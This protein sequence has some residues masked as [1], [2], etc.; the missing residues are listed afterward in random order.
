[1]RH[2]ER[3]LQSQFT[4]AHHQNFNE[5]NNAAGDGSCARSTR[6]VEKEARREPASMSFSQGAV[7]AMRNIQSSTPDRRQRNRSTTGIS[8]SASRSQLARDGRAI[9]RD[10]DRWSFAEVEKK[11]ADFG[12]KRAQ[13][14]KL[15][16]EELTGPAHILDSN[17]G[18]RLDDLHTDHQP[19]AAA[20]LGV[21]ATR[22]TVRERPSSDPAGNYSRFLDHPAIVGR[23]EACFACGGRQGS[24]GR[25]RAVLL[26]SKACGMPQS[27]DVVVIGGRPWRLARDPR[28]AARTKTACI[29][30]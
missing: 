19:A 18:Y 24:A 9:L 23:S 26:I 13:D 28:G 29:D 22:P 6:S 10:A 11:I 20:I 1:V 15:P 4:A 30:D 12:K 2:A 14:G 5:V 27:L 3:W 17:G 8:T 25:P 21:H 7:H 16:I